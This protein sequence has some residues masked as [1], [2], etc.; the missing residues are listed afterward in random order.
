[1][2]LDVKN[3]WWGDGV[4]N[5]ILG[6]RDVSALKASTVRSK[7]T[8]VRFYPLV[9]GERLQKGVGEAGVF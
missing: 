2:W 3:E 8:G 5:F 7:I 1:M 6:E 9:S 4:M